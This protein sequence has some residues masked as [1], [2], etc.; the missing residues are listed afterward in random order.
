MSQRYKDPTGMMYEFSD[1]FEQ[2]A[3]PGVM[4]VRYTS[5]RVEQTDTS[6]TVSSGN[7]TIKLEKLNEFI[8]RFRLTP[9]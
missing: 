6:R 9:Y 4:L 3:R 2:P 7:A 1:P 5:S 8:A